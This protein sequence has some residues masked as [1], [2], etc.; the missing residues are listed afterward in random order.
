[1][2]AFSVFVGST[3]C[4]RVFAAMPIVWISPVFLGLK[5]VYVS[6]CLLLA[7]ITVC[8]DMILL[9]LNFSL[10]ILMHPHCIWS[11]IKVKSPIF[12]L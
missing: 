8:C 6:S 1:M 5:T 2:H 12:F 7:F 11:N 4:V 10:V 3:R 9:A